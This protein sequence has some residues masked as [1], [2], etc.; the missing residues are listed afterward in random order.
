[1]ANLGYLQVTRHCNQKCLFCSNPENP[2]TIS[3]DTARKIFGQMRQ[4]GF[5]GV[6]LTGGEPTLHQELD[7][8]I[9][10]AAATGLAVRIITNGQILWQ[11]SLLDRLVEAGLSH[12]HVSVHSFRKE[13]QAGLAQNPRSLENILKTLDKIGRARITC[14]I[15][16]VICAQ[17]CHHLDENVRFVVERY[18]FVKHF[19]FNNLDPYMNRVA[20]NPHT[21]ARLAD[22]ELSL[23]RALRFLDESGRTFRVE[24][25]PLCYLVDFAWAST[26][27]RKIVKKEKRTVHFLDQKGQITQEDFFHKKSSCCRVC[28]LNSICAGLYDLGGAYDEKE[29]HPVFVDLEPIIGKITG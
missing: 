3:L 14:D 1:M 23:F 18:P 11:N 13:V 6:I 17:N 2:N 10:S 16:T 19:V 7:Q 26:E 4:D 28:S 29:L 22:M 15:N 5:T 8:L 20:E 21:V 24:R 27:T 12:V 9:S 25:V